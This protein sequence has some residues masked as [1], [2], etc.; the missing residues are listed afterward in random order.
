MHLRSSQRGVALITALLIVALAT[1]IS[2]ELSTRLQLDIRR[3][4]NVIASDQAMLYLMEA[5][6]WSRRILKS[7]REDNDFDHLGEDW[8]MEIPPL[9]VEGGSIQGKL[10]D[11]QACFNL[12]S[13]YQDNKKNIL[14]QDRFKRLMQYLEEP[15]GA[16]LSQAIIDWI[17]TNPDTEIPDGAEDGYYL[18]LERPYRNAGQA[19][20][21]L[22]ELRLIKGFEEDASI[23]QSKDW[24][25]AFGLDAPINVNTAPAEVLKSLAANIGDDTVAN[26]IEQRKEEPSETLQGFLSTY[27]LSEIIKETDGLSVSSDYFLLET[28]ANIGQARTL[29]Y[30]IIQ[31]NKDG[32]TEVL[33]RSQGA[34]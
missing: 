15:T 30:S 21:S 28:E 25:C 12:N 8:A 33:T 16:D 13:L 27:K 4:S 29:M 11:L 23:Q 10:S 9:P 3:T 22:S 7:D 6:Y 14:A 2:V 20:Q 31:R 18:N 1:V 17:D 19:I 34:Y 24:L 32:E 26:I 5:E